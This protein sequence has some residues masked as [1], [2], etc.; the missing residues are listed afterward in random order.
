MTLADIII[1]V[2]VIF[3]VTAIIYKMIK[4]KEAPCESCAYLKHCQTGCTIEKK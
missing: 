1:L 3:I 2:V 4:N